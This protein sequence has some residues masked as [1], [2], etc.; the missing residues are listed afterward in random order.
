MVYKKL[1][2]KWWVKNIKKCNVLNWFR[3]MHASNLELQASNFGQTKPHYG[4]YADLVVKIML[5]F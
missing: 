3:L 5:S 1:T 4:G 2:R